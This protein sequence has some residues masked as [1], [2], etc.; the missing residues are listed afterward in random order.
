MQNV[1]LTHPCPTKIFVL[2]T[3][4]FPSLLWMLLPLLTTLCFYCQFFPVLLTKLVSPKLTCKVEGLTYVPYTN[5][6]TQH[7]RLKVAKSLAVHSY[8]IDE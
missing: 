2:L 8:I 5:T 4:I 3:H 6:K 1:Y 7:F